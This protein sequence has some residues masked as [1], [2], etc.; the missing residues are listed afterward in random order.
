MK[1]F[2]S[3]TAVMNRGIDRFGPVI[4]IPRCPSRVEMNA[5]LFPSGD[6]R[7]LLPLHPGGSNGLPEFLNRSQLRR[8]SGC[9]LVGGFGDSLSPTRVSHKLLTVWSPSVAETE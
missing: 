4:Q 9:R 2:V 1:K 3:R 8:G 7:G 5:M 6:Q